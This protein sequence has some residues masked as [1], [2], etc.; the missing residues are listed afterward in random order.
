MNLNFPPIVVQDFFIDTDYAAGAA[1]H[2]LTDYK[3]T[4]GWGAV[5]DLAPYPAQGWLRD[6]DHSFAAGAATRS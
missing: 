2:K 3:V 1:G 4:S 5:H 6:L